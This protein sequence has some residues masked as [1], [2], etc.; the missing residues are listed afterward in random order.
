MKTVPILFTFDQSL[1]MP[2]GVCITSLLDSARPDTFYDIFILHG[3]GCDFSALDIL[4]TRYGN[5]R[6]TIREVKG[7]FVGAYEIRGIPETAYY[8]LLA[9]ELIPEYHKL[10]YS[11]VDVIIREDLAR[12]YDESPSG[13]T[14][15]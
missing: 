15:G 4:K 10:L 9:P 8:R 14:S 1:L 11:D 12:Y 2:A 13:T 7:E 3:P 5:F 6:L